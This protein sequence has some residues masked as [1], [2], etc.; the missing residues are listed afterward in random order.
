[1]PKRAFSRL[2]REISQ[3]LVEDTALE[4]L[5]WQ[6]EALGAL[7]HGAEYFITDVFSM[8]Q[9]AAFHAHRATLMLPDI[10]LVYSM[11]TYGVYDS[12]RGI[13]MASGLKKK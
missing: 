2:V 10:H 4:G 7:Q 11:Q 5:R 1:M 6:G 12:L 8:A 3:D 13:G 9:Y